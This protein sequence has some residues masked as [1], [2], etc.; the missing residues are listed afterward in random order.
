[1]LAFDRQ[2]LESENNKHSNS[3][4]LDITNKKRHI[5]GQP[6]TIIDDGHEDVKHMNQLMLEALVNTIRDQ[7][8]KEKEESFK[9]L[10]SSSI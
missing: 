3:D 2:R 9:K 1:M 7:Q 8:I 10:F 5:L 6:R 4:D